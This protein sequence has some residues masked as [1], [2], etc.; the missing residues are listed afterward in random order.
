M[1]VVTTSVVPSG[2]R[3]NDFSRSLLVRSNDFSR[4]LLVRSNDFSRSLR[5]LK[6]PLNR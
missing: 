3:S 5:S 4:S 2:V 1:F 6:P